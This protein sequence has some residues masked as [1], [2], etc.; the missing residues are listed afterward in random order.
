MI[1]EVIS[2]NAKP[3]IT[4]IHDFTVMRRIIELMTS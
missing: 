4:T 1:E 2:L 3:K